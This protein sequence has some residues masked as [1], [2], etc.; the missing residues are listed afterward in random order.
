MKKIILTVTAIMAIGFV[1][2]QNL[3][4]KKGENYLPEAND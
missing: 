3:K 2:A 1:N 4:S